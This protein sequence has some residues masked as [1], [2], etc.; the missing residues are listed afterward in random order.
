MAKV[1]KYIKNLVEQDPNGIIQ[2]EDY[3]CRSVNDYVPWE[4][5]SGEVTTYKLTPEEM[6][7]YLAGKLKL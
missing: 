4:Q 3:G 7:A 2:M 6:E 5:L 1:S